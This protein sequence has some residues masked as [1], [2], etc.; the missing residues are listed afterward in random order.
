MIT[1]LRGH[2]SNDLLATDAVLQAASAV[3]NEPRSGD[4]DDVT[5]HPLTYGSDEGALAVRTEIA[6]WTNKKH[7]TDHGTTA[8]CINLTNGASFGAA[9]ALIQCCPRGY[10][11]RAFAVSPTYYLINQIF[12]DAGFGDR[13]TAVVE[14]AGGLDFDALERQL[15]SQ[16]EDAQ[17]EDTQPEDAQR[18][19]LQFRYVLYMVP[20]FSNPGGYT[21]D[22]TEARRLLELARKYDMLLLCDNVYDEL[23]YDPEFKLPTPLVRMDRETLPENSRGNVIANCSFSKYL[24]PGLRV[25]WQECATPELAYHLSQSGANKSGGSPSHLNTFIVG[26]ILR[27]GAI[28]TVL[29]RLRKV[30]GDRSK[31]YVGFIKQYLPKGTKISGGEGGYFLWLTFPDEYDVPAITEECKRRGIVLAPGQNFEVIGDNKGWGDHCFRVSVSYHPAAE[32]EEAFR[33][34]GE[35]AEAERRGSSL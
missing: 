15:E 30:Y 13:M 29:K 5:R 12:Q 32:A 3:L 26:E 35:V 7:G 27:S 9:T 28:E 2:P 21:L 23:N 4:N 19:P 1:L 34:W 16:P 22:E 24:G 17:P 11:R 6:K 10:T 20:V 33:I 8:E 25:G 14:T 31:A 18:K